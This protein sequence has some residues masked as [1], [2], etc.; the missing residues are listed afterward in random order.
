MLMK[1][2]CSEK[3][4]VTYVLYLLFVYLLYY[5]V[6]YDINMQFLEFNKLFEEY[7]IFFK[8]YFTQVTCELKTIFFVTLT[9]KNTFEK[10][11][12]PM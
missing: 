8:F 6:I 2:I 11:F 9:Y 3:V 10:L 12:N 5:N 4:N 7:M 1:I